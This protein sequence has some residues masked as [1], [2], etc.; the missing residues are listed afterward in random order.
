MVNPNDA[1]EVV[2]FLTSAAVIVY[3]QKYLKGS[4]LTSEWYA[5]FVAAVPGSDKWAHRIIA[6]LGS[7]VAALGIHMTFAGDFNNGWTFA[8]QIPNG[9]ELLHATGDFIKVF[10][11][12]QWAYDSSRRPDTM[13]HDISTEART[14]AGGAN[15]TGAKNP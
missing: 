8:G 10:A 12:Q 13:H 7:F 6:G 15:T 14:A 2:P 4:R 3:I 1:T 5:K 9:W 11:L